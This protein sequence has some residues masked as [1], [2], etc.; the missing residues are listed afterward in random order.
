MVNFSTIRGV[1]IFRNILK[2]SNALYLLFLVVCCLFLNNS[3]LVSLA[4]NNF[5]APDSVIVKKPVFTQTGIA[6]L[7]AKK[8]H[9]RK[10][11]SGEKFNMYALTAAHRTL[12][13]GTVVKVTNLKNNKSVTVRI[14]D[15]GPFI[16]G[17]VIDL[18]FAAAQK[19]GFVQQG[20]T[21]V[22]I[23]TVDGIEPDDSKQ[24]NYAS[25]DEKT[26]YSVQV[27][28]FINIENAEK[29][30]KSLIE[31]NFKDITILQVVKQETVYRVI[32]GI[33]STYEEANKQKEILLKNNTEGFIIRN[34]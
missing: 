33:F 15:R 1:K 6:S 30:K 14:N 17:R 32:V 10:T 4:G 27:G 21:S 20:I 19:L 25:E 28:A 24:E 31:K 2:Y 11:A 13:F 3:P 26:Y 9:K 8:F 16:K 22:K 7:Y 12:K 29:F 18:S 5:L 23:E 34:N